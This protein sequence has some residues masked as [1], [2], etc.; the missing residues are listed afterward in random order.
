MLF[1]IRMRMANC[2]TSLGIG[3][4]NKYIHSEEF[5]TKQN[6]L[7][8]VLWK[9]EECC[10]LYHNSLRLLFLLLWISWVKAA[11]GEPQH[12]RNSIMK[13]ALT[14]FHMKR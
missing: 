4:N 10:L 5:K 7:R 13:K 3:I 8:S 12:Q 14:Y 9:Q 2:H 1:Q 11:K 6:N